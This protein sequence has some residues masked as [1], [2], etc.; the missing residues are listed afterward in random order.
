MKAI[1]SIDYECYILSSLST[2]VLHLVVDYQT[3][4]NLWTTLEIALVSPSNSRVIQLYGAFQDL[5]KNDDYVS[6][7]L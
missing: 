4:H 5:R 3:S 7:Y 6:V 2:K 1:K